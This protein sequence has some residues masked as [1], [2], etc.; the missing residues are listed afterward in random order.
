[1]P[2]VRRILRCA[3]YPPQLQA[4]S[5]SRWHENSRCNSDSVSTYGLQEISRKNNQ[6]IRKCLFES[7]Q[8]LDLRESHVGITGQSPNCDYAGSCP[9][10]TYS[11]S[12]SR[13]R[14]DQLL[15]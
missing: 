7:E 3:P 10:L 1:M 4:L 6:H 9:F 11:G 12:E 14:I 8:L 2:L 5:T 15:P 13:S